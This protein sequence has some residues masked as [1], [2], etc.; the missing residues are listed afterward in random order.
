[1]N[2]KLKRF[3]SIADN[4]GNQSKRQ[5]K[6]IIKDIT[7]LSTIDFSKFTKIIVAYEDEQNNNIRSIVNNNIDSGE[8]VA[9]FI[10][11]EGGFDEE[12]IDFLKKHGAVC[13]SLGK[14]I[15]RTETAGLA[16]IAALTL[17]EMHYNLFRQYKLVQD[18]MM[19]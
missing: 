2:Q 5:K 15:L 4:A 13:I 9:I 10:G 7:T 1:M 17:G 19:K 8:E 12:E 3:Q 11:S 16:T 18:L 14:R 6:C